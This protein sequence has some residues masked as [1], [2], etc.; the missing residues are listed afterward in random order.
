MGSSDIR[1]LALAGPFVV[2][3]GVFPRVATADQHIV[4][5]PS[6]DARQVRVDSPAGW[7][8]IF[9]PTGVLPLRGVQAIFVDRSLR[10]DAWGEL[11]DPPVTKRGHE[12]IVHYPLPADA[13]KYVV[14]DYGQRVYQA[15]KVPAGTTECFIRYRQG[16]AAHGKAVDN[17]VSDITCR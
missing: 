8:G 1:F 4:C 7:V 5:P 16:K 17:V 13:E 15:M 6:V 12:V 14:C 3:L 9:G 11:K 2:V 10:D